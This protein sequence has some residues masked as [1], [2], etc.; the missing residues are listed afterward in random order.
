M[1]ESLRKTGEKRKEKR[2]A[3][4]ERKDAEKRAR[5]DEIR[6]L[7]ALKRKE[8]EAKLQK[9]KQ[10]AGDDIE[11]NFNDIEDDF[12]PAVYDKRMEVRFLF[13]SDINIGVL[14]KLRNGFQT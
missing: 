10:L 9:L 12:D 5:K 3:Y 2:T 11:I 7:K 6:E 14:E 1:K 8:I 13:T 4:K